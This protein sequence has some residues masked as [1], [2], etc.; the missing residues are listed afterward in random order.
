MRRRAVGAP[1]DVAQRTAGRSFRSDGYPF[2]RAFVAQVWAGLA[3]LNRRP[4]LR[5]AI[6]NYESGPALFNALFGATCATL[7][8]R[9]R[10]GI[11]YTQ[12]RNTPFSG[13]A[14]DGAKLALWD[15]LHQGFN[16]VAFVH[17]EIVVE[18]RYTPDA[19][20]GDNDDGGDD[21][22]DD[23]DAYSERAE[24]LDEARG[25]RERWRRRCAA[26]S[27][28]THAVRQIAV[29]AM[30][31]VWCAHVALGVLGAHRCAQPQR[32]DQ[33]LVGALPALVEAARRRRRRWRARAV[34]RRHQMKRTVR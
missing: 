1:L 5:A 12:A 14:A 34:R 28:A 26:L 8:G 10:G 19:D 25:D 22:D 30:Q 15:L 17:D 16:V 29:A 9:L 11:S 4:E 24:R 20:L 23:D 2:K 13:L 6:A 27:E 7:T 33:V 32:A 21:G 31:R 18:L 3:R